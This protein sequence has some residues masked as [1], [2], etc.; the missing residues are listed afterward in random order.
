MA[1]F[2][3]LKDRLFKS[4]NKLEEG[5]D[6]I[7]E[8]G[9]EAAAPHQPAPEKTPD[10]PPSAPP[11]E[12]PAEQPVE[13]PKA[14]PVEVPSEA[15]SEIPV[16]APAEI[17]AQTP[18]QSPR[19]AE[20]ITKPAEPVKK[21]AEPMAKPSIKPTVAPDPTPATPGLLGR[22]MGR[23]KADEPRRA[24]DDEM[25]EQLEDLLVGADMGVDTALRVTANMAEGRFGKRLS[26]REIK[27]LLAAEVARIM[28]PVARPMPIYQKRPQVVLVVGVNGSG[29]TTTIGKLASQFKA[30]GKKVVI[31]A[32]DT[33]RAAAVE[34]L[35]VWGDRAGVPV[36][37]APEGSDPAS[38]AF[39][40]MTRAQEDGA[41][42]LMID[43]AG[44]LQNRADLMEELA[45]I[46]R[47][48]R[49]KDETAP[50]NTLLV[51][52]ATTGQNALNQVETFQKLADVSGLVMTKLDGTAKGGV[53]V[54]LADRFGLPIHAIGV[55][56]QIDDLA[57]FDP[58]EFAAALTGLERS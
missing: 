23:G 29:K 8:E 20:P 36:L 3:K 13:A 50:H 42:L 5:L 54:A 25:L 41:D 44:R 37:T 4:S 49:K 6:A 1:F 39:D 46:V 55:G 56:E 27:E 35:Q 34:Q 43:T 18:E 26:T 28:E 48:I 11:V 38:L 16:D 12:G 7:V 58:E 31:A 22:L 30:A 53:L 45:K 57:P 15:P 32:G 52:D 40:A 33:F 51:L 19:P 21:P 10:V 47:V 14:P 9:A 2:S 24:L 17:P